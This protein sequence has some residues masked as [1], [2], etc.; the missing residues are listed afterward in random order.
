MSPRYRRVTCMLWTA[1]FAQYGVMYAFETFIPTILSS[2]G[3]SMVKSFEFSIVIYSGMIPAFILAG[4]AVEW[5]DRKWTILLGFSAT[6]VFTTLFSLASTPAEFMLFGAVATSS[7]AFGGTAIYTYTPELY[8][9]EVRATGMGIASAWGRAGAVA[10]L[11]IFGMF[12]TT[13][14]KSL[15]LFISD[16]VL[17]VGFI[18]VAWLGP[19]TRG[20]RLEDTS[21]GTAVNQEQGAGPSVYNLSCST[22]SS[23]SATTF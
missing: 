4:R 2:E 23:P 7:F 1:W 13:V 15:L 5:L 18:M 14:G 8:P 20:R 21:Q 22:S 16:S 17:L 12:F 11:L 9:T 10:L 6:A 3:Y 19:P